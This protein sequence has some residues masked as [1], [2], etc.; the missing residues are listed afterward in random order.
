[1]VEVE[2]AMTEAEWLGCM[3]PRTMLTHLGT[4]AGARKVRLYACA[5]ANHLSRFLHDERSRRAIDVAEQFADGRVTR[6]DLISAFRSAREVRESLEAFGGG[7]M[8]QAA[9]H[10][11]CDAA[12][13]IWD[14]EPDIGRAMASADLAWSINGAMRVARCELLLDVFGNPFRSVAVVSGLCSWNDSAIPKLAGAVYD[15][16]AFDRLPILADALE[17]VGCTDRAILDHCR[18]PG[19]HVRGCWVVDRILGKS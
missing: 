9:A 5:F 11:A 14:L 1:V 10:A 2:E 18:G 7:R 15:Q 6:S 4:K 13:L 16:R 12:N 19:P 8:E 17:D 3:E